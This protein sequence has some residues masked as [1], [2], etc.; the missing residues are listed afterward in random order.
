M[1]IGKSERRSTAVSGWVQRLVLQNGAI[2]GL[3][4]DGRLSVGKDH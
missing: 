4:L 3:Q 1:W 2:D